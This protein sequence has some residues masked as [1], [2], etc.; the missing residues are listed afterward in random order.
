MIVS[1]TWVIVKGRWG[2]RLIAVDTV[3]QRLPTGIQSNV[4]MT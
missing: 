2:S 4:S 1:N 3:S